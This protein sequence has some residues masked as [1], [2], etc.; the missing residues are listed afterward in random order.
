MISNTT[1]VFYKDPYDIIYIV[2]KVDYVNARDIEYTTTVLD[3][4][5]YGSAPIAKV[6]DGVVYKYGKIDIRKE[7]FSLAGGMGV[8][9][10]AADPYFFIADE[11]YFNSSNAGRQVTIRNVVRNNDESH[12]LYIYNATIERVIDSKTITINRIFNNTIV[13]PHIG[14]ALISLEPGYRLSNDIIPSQYISYDFIR[15]TYECNDGAVQCGSRVVPNVNFRFGPVDAFK[16]HLDSQPID[17]VDSY[18]SDGYCWVDADDSSCSWAPVDEF[19][20][21]NGQEA[22]ACPNDITG[23]SNNVV[24]WVDVWG[25][26][27]C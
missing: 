27:Q 18:V 19:G 23:Y 17:F 8:F 10:D 25:D 7:V 13:P 2:D 6:Q 4:N 5:I 21:V 14:A 24:T 26:S 15:M 20:S 1:V 12:T 22:T 11:P 3:P 16:F 9:R